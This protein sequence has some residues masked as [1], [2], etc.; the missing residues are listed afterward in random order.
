[1]EKKDKNEIIEAGRR[2]VPAFYTFSF[3][4]G[5]LVAKLAISY[6]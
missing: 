3:V 1:V 6:F 5:S 2:Y 4:Q